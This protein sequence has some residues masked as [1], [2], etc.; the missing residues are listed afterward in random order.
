MAMRQRNAQRRPGGDQRVV[1][2]VRPLSPAAADVILRR[3]MRKWD[4]QAEEE[5][6]GRDPHRRLAQ[7]R[8][9]RS[10]WAD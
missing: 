3:Y 9:M 2:T 10:R 4:A 7:L 5:R 8:A 6:R 1:I